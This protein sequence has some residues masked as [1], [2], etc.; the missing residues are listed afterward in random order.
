MTRKR[1]TLADVAAAAVVSASTASLVMTGRGP[2][3]RISPAV[4]ERVRAEAGRLGYRPN[5]VSVGLR[6]GTSRT[7]GFISD[8]VATSQV[9]GRMI[10]GAIEAAK[11]QGFMLFISETEASSAAERDLVHAMSDRQID[12]L[13][14]ATM[15][16]RR[17]A[18][19]RAAA[20]VPVVLLNSVSPGQ[21]RVDS[22]LP[23]EV[24]A[25]RAA[26]QVL[27]DHGHRKIHLLG[28]GPRSGDVPRDS[29]AGQE[30]LEGIH[31]ALADVELWPAS[32]TALADW[33][34]TLGRTGAEQL[35]ERDP[36]PGAIICFN[37]RVAFA[38]YQVLHEAGLR[39]PE[40]VSVISFDDSDIA[41]WM[42]P[43]LTTV[44]LPHEA[45]GRMAVEL[46]LERISRPTDQPTLPQ[47]HRI[48]MPL[49]VRESVGAPRGT[50]PALRD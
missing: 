21:A 44:A 12:G 39:I 16:T 32:H 34:P 18:V 22:V 50:P 42:R 1:V 15:F 38:T 45:M 7:L 10:L 41:G 4:Q 9:A 20:N 8:S 14:L 36:D 28:A 31:A 49:H 11:E 17:H 48:P 29:I 19:P 27:L 47:T 43:G 6:T 26:A 13:I 25:G 37:D 33:T 24:A 2:E 5:A 35:L 23:D 30:R 3:L 40:D 46:L